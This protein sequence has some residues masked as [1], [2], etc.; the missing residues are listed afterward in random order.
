MAER[1]F[2]YKGYRFTV[3]FNG[4][5]VGGFQKVSGLNVEADVV[6]YREGTDPPA[7]RKDPGLVSVGTVT[8]SRGVMKK[9]TQLWD[10][11]RKLGT[12]YFSPDENPTG[13]YAE[14]GT[15][16]RFNLVITLQDRSGKGVVRWILYN[17]F[18]RRLEFSDLGEHDVVVETLQVEPEGISFEFLD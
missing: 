8:L 11:F 1:Q 5:D 14:E 6:N 17:C 12:G 10:Y 9:R 2:P 15:E 7:Q 13:A 4:E 3:T 18:P 16:A